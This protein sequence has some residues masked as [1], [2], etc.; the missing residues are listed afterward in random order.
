[1]ERKRRTPLVLL[2]SSVQFYFIFKVG[3]LIDVLQW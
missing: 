2:Y 3:V 1:M